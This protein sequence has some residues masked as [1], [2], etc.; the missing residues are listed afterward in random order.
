MKLLKQLG[1]DALVYGFGGA[2]AKGLSFLLLPIYT[3]I[4]TPAEYGTM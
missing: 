4:F 3:R 1:G 2:I